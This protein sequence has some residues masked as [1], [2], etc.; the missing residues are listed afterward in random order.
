MKVSEAVKI[1][2]FHRVLIKETLVPDIVQM[3]NDNPGLL[4]ITTVEV[5]LAA[6]ANVDFVDVGNEEA[7]PT[8]THTGL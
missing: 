2:R 1:K 6:C 7:S 8:R 4:L 5:I 3:D